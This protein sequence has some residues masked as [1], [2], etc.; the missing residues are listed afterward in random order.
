MKRQHTIALAMILP[1]TFFFATTGGKLQSCD[2][3]PTWSTAVELVL[4]GQ[5]DLTRYVESP[6]EGRWQSLAAAGH[7]YCVRPSPTYSGWYSAYP[8]GTTVI[9]LPVVAVCHSCGVNIESDRVL[10]RIEYWTAAFVA[11]VML[12]LF[13]LT[14]CQLASPVTA[15]VTTLLLA[16]GSVFLSTLGQILWHQDG[17]ILA[18]FVVLHIELRKRGVVTRGGTII[19]ALALAMAIA[20]RPTSGLFAATFV[21]WVLARD[22][23]RGVLLAMTTAVMF[24]PWIAYYYSLYRSVL[25]PAMSMANPLFWDWGE[26]V[27]SVLFSPGRGLFV[28]QPFLILLALYFVPRFGLGLERWPRFW[29]AFVIA[30][31][32][33]HCFLIGSWNIWWGGHCYGSRLVAETVPVLMLALVPIIERLL[34]RAGGWLLLSLIVLVSAGVHFAAIKGGGNSWN[35][36]PNDIDRH[37]DRLWDWQDAPFLS[38]K[39]RP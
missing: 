5:C 28:Y 8:A 10:L 32:A 31:V 1:L 27:G 17:V 30:F 15:A 25:G 9:A 16:T 33:L 26:H 21:L 34:Q 22:R 20:C 35:N 23:K 11:V 3:L 19:Q 2:T 39:R 29:F 13:Y 18:I 24:L 38:L 6:P 4:R 37:P 14:V 36:I 7:F 12:A